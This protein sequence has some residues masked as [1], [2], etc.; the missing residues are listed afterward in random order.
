[1]KNKHEELEVKVPI[2]VLGPSQFNVAKVNLEYRYKVIIKC[3][4]NNEFRGFLKAVLIQCYSKLTK[5]IN[6]TIAFNNENEV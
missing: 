4:D 2:K 5:K 6:I 3:V 1:M